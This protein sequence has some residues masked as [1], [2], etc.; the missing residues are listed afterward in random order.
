M[1]RARFRG[2]DDAGAEVEQ[3]VAQGLGFDDDSAVTVIL[4]VRAYHRTGFS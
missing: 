4:A 1:L 2:V 3:P